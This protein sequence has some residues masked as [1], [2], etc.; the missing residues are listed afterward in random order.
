MNSAV[1]VNLQVLIPGEKGTKAAFSNLSKSGS[2]ANAYN[3]LLLADK[4]V[5]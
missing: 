2:I 3:A 4:M 1:K 5:N